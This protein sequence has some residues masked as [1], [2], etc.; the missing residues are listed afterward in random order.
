MG[1]ESTPTAISPSGVIHVYFKMR[2]L[3]NAFNVEQ[4]SDEKSKVNVQVKDNA[5]IAPKERGKY[6]YFLKATWQKGYG[7]Y[8]FSVSVE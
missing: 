4:W 8:A 3:T 7:N 6:I 5:I 1:R 2:P